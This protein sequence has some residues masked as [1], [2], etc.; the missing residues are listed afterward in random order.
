MK[1]H[2]PH[3]RKTHSQTHQEHTR[4]QHYPHKVLK[5]GNAPDSNG[6]EQEN[7]KGEERLATFAKLGIEDVGQ[8]GF[9][10]VR[11]LLDLV[12]VLLN[13]FGCGARV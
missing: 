2:L 8:K 4:T 6:E 10:L 3:S 12:R 9:C 1:I 7:L 5:E 11:V 13:L